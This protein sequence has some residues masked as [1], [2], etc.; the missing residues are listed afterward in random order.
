MNYLTNYYKNLCEKLQYKATKLEHL[1]ES[2]I[3]DGDGMGGPNDMSG[4]N[5]VPP[6]SIPAPKGP[7]PTPM[8]I[9]PTSDGPTIPGN[10]P[11]PPTRFQL[12][13]IDYEDIQRQMLDIEAL[14][15]LLM[16]MRYG[17]GIH[18]FSRWLW[19]QFGI[20]L[21]DDPGDPLLTIQDKIRRALNAKYP[22]GSITKEQRKTLE[23]ILENNWKRLLEVWKKEI[24]RHPTPSYLDVENW[25][26]PPREKPNPR[27][28]ERSFERWNRQNY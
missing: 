5:R 15:Q 11:K 24:L 28:R 2:I 7:R 13:E 16:R 17:N 18:I 22:P 10:F 6:G 23:Q 8:Y 4:R 12:P 21:R 27:A 1:V 25:D 9:V 19:L 3:D 26:T 14:F 20:R